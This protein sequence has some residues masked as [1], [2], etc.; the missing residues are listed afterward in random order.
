MSAGPSPTRSPTPLPTGLDPDRSTREWCAWWTIRC[1]EAWPHSPIEALAVVAYA[2]IDLIPPAS[3]LWRTTAR[4]AQRTSS[5][6]DAKERANAVLQ[7]YV[8]VVLVLLVA[9]LVLPGRAVH[10]AAGV[11]GVLRLADL[12][13]VVMGILLFKG[14]NE[15]TGLLISAAAVYLAQIVLAYACISQAWLSP[16]LAAHCGSL[17]VQICHPAGWLHYL[18]VATTNV[19]TLG[20]E[21]APTSSASRIVTAL[22]PVSGVVFAGAVLTQILGHTS[23]RPGHSNAHAKCGEDQAGKDSLG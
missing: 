19:F 16:D 4:L 15:A 18:Y 17:Q 3:V 2:T 6:A 7:W 21:Y 11:L 10:D 5:L 22:E 23:N 14:T 9:G 12:L 20:N 8:L 1:Q 13:P